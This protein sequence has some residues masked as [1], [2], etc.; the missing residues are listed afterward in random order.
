MPKQNSA[1]LLNR[2]IWLIDTIYT[3]GH[4]SREE[5]DCRW[6]RSLL[7]E[8]EMCIPERT[9]HRYKEAIQEL[10]QINIGF[11]KLKGY[12]IENTED[13]KRDGM[14]KWLIS[15]F[16]V[17][18]LL[19]E[20]QHLKDHIL[21]EP[22]PSGH[23][24]L[25]AIMESIRDGVKLNVS[26]QGYGKAE[27]A[28]FPLLPYCLKAFKQ[29][30]YVLAESAYEDHSLRVYSLDRF[31]SVERTEEPY[32]IPN[33]FDGKEYFSKFY[34]ISTPNKADQLVLVHIRFSEQQA[35]FVRSLPIHPSQKEL[36]TD[37]NGTTFSYFLI[38]NY[39]FCH[40][41][42]THGSG[43]EVLSPAS[44]REWFRN[45]IDK[46]NTMYKS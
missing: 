8:G 4:I 10:F 15:T 11:S 40:E 7:S 33:G 24:F 25:S 23:M 13:I 46:M 36:Q 14:R 21:L 38:P 2:Y 22:M 1:I 35:H 19:N 44:L 43:A 39:E 18:N 32:S 31:V 28:T 6:C 3:A 41:I 26:Y 45:E 20:G 37:D 27:P 5:I 34:G 30:W 29:R 12:Y 16:A 9:F 42:L 17:N